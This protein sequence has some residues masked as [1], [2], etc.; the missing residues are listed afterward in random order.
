VGNLQGFAIHHACSWFIGAG[1]GEPIA[2]AALARARCARRSGDWLASALADRS[3]AALPQAEALVARIVEIRARKHEE[4]LQAVERAALESEQTRISL[5][6]EAEA[7]AKR[8]AAVA[9]REQER[10]QAAADARA[11]AAERARERQYERQ[12]E[13]ERAREQQS[14]QSHSKPSYRS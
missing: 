11:A 13:E 8:V 2:K 14:A 5:Q 3:L 1:A 12:R 10:R 9:R 7:E 6:K 4:S